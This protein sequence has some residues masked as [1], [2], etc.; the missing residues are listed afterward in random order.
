MNTRTVS[1]SR[2]VGTSGEEVAQ[3][4]ASLVDFRYIDYQVIQDAAAAAGVSPETV[5]E[6]EHS[7]SLMTRILEGLA[8]N[9]GTVAAGWSEPVPVAMNPVF[10]SA[11]YRAFLERVIRELADRGGS[12]I[13][14]HA[15][16]VILRDRLD[17][18]KVL[19][20]GSPDFRGRRI[21]AAMAVDEKAAMK[22]IERT[23]HERIEYFNR[24]YNVGWLVPSAHD[25]CLNTDHINPQQA[26]ELIVE[27]ARLR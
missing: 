5:S 21:M 20:T 8:R 6:A 26:A 22:I 10:T 14:G 17:T 2:Q 24:A 11:D 7:P 15:S 27:I 19:I 9:P 18:L 13:V 16:H 23:D 1:I 4:V 3:A 12:V 25:I